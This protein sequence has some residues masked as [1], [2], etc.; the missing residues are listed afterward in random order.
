[1]FMGIK[2]NLQI[3]WVYWMMVVH[4]YL[5]A[6]LFCP[7]IYESAFISFVIL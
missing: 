2:K 6:A 4:V 5:K 1:M 7:L 3:I